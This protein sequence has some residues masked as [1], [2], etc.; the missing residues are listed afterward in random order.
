MKKG[1]TESYSFL[2]GIIITVLILTAIGCAVY[3]MYKPKSADYFG[4]LTDLLKK[5]EK[6]GINVPDGEI[7]FYIEKD[8]ALIGFGKNQDYIGEQGTIIRLICYGIGFESIDRPTKCPI[9]KSCLCLCKIGYSHLTMSYEIREDACQG[10]VRCETFDILD[11]ER[12]EGCPQGVIIP[13]MKHSFA[14]GNFERGVAIL[15]YSKQG[16]IVSIDD[17]KAVISKEK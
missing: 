4:K 5:L 16:N 11:F 14:E 2:I 17:E 15:Y 13:G 9:D 12:G 1:Q 8:Q 6:Q 7:T 10:N 3:N